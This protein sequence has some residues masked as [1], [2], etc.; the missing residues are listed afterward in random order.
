[1]NNAEALDP[2]LQAGLGLALQPEFIVWKA[3]E[4]GL[5]EEVLSDWEVTPIALNIVSPPG[6]RRPAR[7]TALADHLVRRL[8]AAP[9]AKGDL[10]RE[11]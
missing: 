1:V 3:L 5:L 4:A 7:V 6:S 11:A 8:G 10:L 9:W 2:A